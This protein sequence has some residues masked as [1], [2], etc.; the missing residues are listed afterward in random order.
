MECRRVVITGL[1]AIAPNGTG[2][3]AFWSALKAGESGIA[4]IEHFDPADFSVQICG[5]VK[6]YTATDHFPVKEARHLAR[7]TQFA[8]VA[9]REAV[10]SA[11]LDLEKVDPERMGVMIGSGIGSMHTIEEEHKKLLKRGPGRVSPFLIPQIIVNEAAGQVAIETG[12]QNCALCVVTACATGTNAIGDAFRMIKY[13]DADVMFAGGTENA[14][15]PL[16][17]AGFASLKALSTR[18][19]E[20][21]RA[22]RPF[23][24]ERD[25]FIMG[26]GAGVMILENL[27]HAKARGADILAEVVGYGRTSDAYH[28]TA[29]EPSGRGAIKAMRDAMTEGGLKPQDVD[30]INAHGTSTKMN[31]KVETAAIKTA[32]GDHAQKVAVSS[33]KSMTGHL[34]G[35]AGGIEAV[36]SVMAIQDGVLPPTINYENP[37]PDCDLDYIPNEARSAEVGAVLSNSLGFGGHNATLAF[38]KFAE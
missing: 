1:G 8:V 33:T 35:G 2:V 13:G 12:A 19:D 24:A 9:A 6:D 29:P 25:G 5:R 32:L 21:E 28:V 20:P 3:N 11:K 36:A 22:S 14:T 15:T 31:D 34:L 18:N 17:V 30:Y 10:Q 4:R 7:F 16:S 38:K 27:E 37:D 26:E 23:D